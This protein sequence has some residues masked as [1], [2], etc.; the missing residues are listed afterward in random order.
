MVTVVDAMQAPGGAAGRVVA[1]ASQA[2]VVAVSSPNE[3]FEGV[4]RVYDFST[5]GIEQVLSAPDQGISDF[6]SSLAISADGTVLAVGAP[7]ANGGLGRVYIYR[8]SGLFFGNP[9]QRGAELIAGGFGESLALSSDGSHLAVGAPL[10]AGSTG[11]VL[12]YRWT[13]ADWT[14]PEIF[15]GPNPQSRFG[16]ALVCRR[17]ATDALLVI[18]APGSDSVYIHYG[19]P[20][21]F[22]ESTQL[23]APRTE[24]RFGAALS[25]SG[26]GTTLVV[27]DPADSGASW[28]HVYTGSAIIWISRQVI[29]SPA[30]GDRFGAAL[31]LSAD[32]GVLAIGARSYPPNG[33]VQLFT[34]AADQ[35]VERN[36]QRP[37]HDLAAAFGFSVGL[38]RTGSILVVGAPEFVDGA[39]QF[40]RYCVEDGC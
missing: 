24:G 37:T 8:R 30:L 34:R 10:Y 11:R 25:L 2:K 27:G 9:A 16:S 18:G 13:G 21:S 14:Q 29:E 22:S 19:S 32:G 20:N 3:N 6:G 15:N 33:R 31:S 36:T 5:G 23:I 7:S 28:V 17:G 4:V 1:V 39:G 38:N 40:Y 12:L 26:D 35:F